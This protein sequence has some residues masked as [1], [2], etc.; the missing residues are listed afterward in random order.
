MEQPS[1]TRAEALKLVKK[2]ECL[3]YPFPKT[4]EG[5][6]GLVDAFIEIAGTV[7]RAEWL[8]SRVLHGCSQ[9]PTPIEMRRIADR[10]FPAADGKSIQEV[11]ASDM[12]GAGSKKKREE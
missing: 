10:K 9:C 11:D 6:M 1:I 4:V 3:G 12:M 5:L 8:C 7:D 2:W